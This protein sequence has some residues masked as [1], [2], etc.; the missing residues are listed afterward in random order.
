VTDTA[1]PGSRVR[2]PLD[3]DWSLTTARRRPVTLDSTS[4]DSLLEETDRPVGLDG[5]F[6][7]E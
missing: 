6:L 5:E 4:F 7:D 1:G 3:G 2:S